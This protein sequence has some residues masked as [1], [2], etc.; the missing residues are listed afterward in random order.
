[1]L[2]DSQ[3]ETQSVLYNIDTILI[4]DKY[5]QIQRIS[6]WFYDDI[7]SIDNFMT[8]RESKLQWSNLELYH[9]SIYFSFSN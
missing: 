8:K 7:I 6:T 1:M 3:S 2:K 4:I 5:G 9:W